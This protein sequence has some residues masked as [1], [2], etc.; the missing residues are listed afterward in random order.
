MNCVRPP[1]LKKPSRGFAWACGP[2]SRAQERKLEARNTPLISERL[3]PEEEE[4]FEEE[5][6]DG[7]GRGNGSP[8]A[9][10]SE[11]K[12]TSIRPATAEQSAHAKLWPYRYLGQHCRVEDALDYDDRIYPRASSR[13]G[14]RHQAIVTTWPGRPVEYVKPV[15]VKKK[16]VKGSN[17]KKDSKLSKDAAAALEADKIAKVKRPK[18]VL[19]EPPGYVHRG[20]DKDNDL[21]DCTAKLLFKL[22]DADESSSKS[23]PLPS[24]SDER[25]EFLDRYISQVKGLAGEIGVQPHSTNLLDK[26]LEILYQHKFNVEASLNDVRKLDKHKDLKE[27]DLN[28]EEQKRFEE[29]VS[30]FGSEL[31]S[32]TRHVRTVKHADIVR[33]YYVWKKTDKGRQI[34]G[35]YEGR[36]GKKE[37]KRA[38]GSKLVDDVADDEDDSAFDDEKATKRKKGFE[39]KFCGSR[40]SRLWRRAPGAA[41]GTIVPTD[42]STKGNSKDKGYQFLV[43]L[44]R[45]CAELWRRYGIQWEDIDEVAKKVAQGGGKAWKRKIDEELLKELVSTSYAPAT[46]TNGTATTSVSAGMSSA[47]PVTNPHPPDPPKKKRKITPD[48][49]SGERNTR[50]SPV[51][52]TTAATESQKK[53]EKVVEKAPTP[54]PPPVPEIPKPKVMP[55]AICNMIEPMD[56]QHLSCREC[57]LT[58]HRNCYGVGE[59][60]NATKWICDMCVNDKNPQVSTVR[61]CEI[62]NYLSLKDLLTKRISSPTNASYVP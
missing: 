14:A 16:Y 38:D 56:D 48:K 32:I 13:L 10:D 50:T 60:R 51:T 37:A 47:S 19:D 39:C 1:L 36:R 43:A 28:K 54:A 23:S 62:R 61:S 31:H 24:S 40:S 27:P 12:D 2:C 58:I 15:D 59:V 55:C 35:N 4:I 11:Q 17:N 9:D 45:R 6:D 26:A 5:E 57:R 3:E 18:W 25:E 41:P 42:G 34:W 49:E 30:K 33:Y 22:P 29:G 7:I 20:E 21:P 8:D 44:C 46:K 52:T 53:K